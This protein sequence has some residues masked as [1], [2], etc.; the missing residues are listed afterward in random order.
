MV[1]G[2]RIRRILNLT[3]EHEISFLLTVQILDRIEIGNQTPLSVSIT[4]W[5]NAWSVKHYRSWRIEITFAFQIKTFTQY[6]LPDRCKWK[7]RITAEDS[8]SLK[9][10]FGLP[11]SVKVFLQCI[12]KYIMS[13]NLEEW[14]PPLI[15]AG[16]ARSCQ[17]FR[18]RVWYRFNV[19][20]VSSRLVSG[21]S[22]LVLRREASHW[23]ISFYISWTVF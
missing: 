21:T 8:W 16:Q 17:A 4:R 15:K 18:S 2:Q 23:I 10:M 22:T 13:V 9:V 12:L 1:G 11:K 19:L 5:A 3:D 6:S 7:L 14:C 20:V